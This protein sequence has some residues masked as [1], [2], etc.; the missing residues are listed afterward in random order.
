MLTIHGDSRSGN[1]Y[2]LQLLAAHLRIPHRWRE[3]DVLSGVT[4]QPEFLA[5]NPNGRIPLIEFEDGRVLPESNAGLMY[6]AHGSEL[7][8]AD[9]FEEAQVL[10]WLFFEQYSHEPYI[11]TVRFWQHFLGG[12]ERYTDRYGWRIKPGYAALDVMEQHLQRHQFFVADRYSVADIALFAYTH[13]AAEGGFDLQ[14]YAAIRS[15][16]DRVREQPGFVAMAAVLA[17]D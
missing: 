12:D 1:C 7:R 3:V 6:L 9:R 8:P 4:R 17:A 14:A 16:L 15:W 13:V 11:A 10:Q 2:K 5:K